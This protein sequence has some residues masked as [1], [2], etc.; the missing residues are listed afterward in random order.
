MGESQVVKKGKGPREV[1]TEDGK[2]RVV[3]DGWVLLP[4][5]DAAL[6]R[7]V[8]KAGPHYQVQE[9]RGRK[10]FSHGVWAPK[11]TIDREVARRAVEKED[12]AYQ[13]KLEVG[14]QR[15]A[16]QEALYGRVFEEAVFK[17]L[18]FHRRFGLLARRLSVAIAAHATPVGSGTV[19]RTK[20]ISVEERADAAI[21]AWMRHHT[22]DYDHMSIAR[23]KGERRRVRRELAKQSVALLERYRKGEAVEMCLLTEGLKRAVKP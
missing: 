13:K 22:T 11:E 6:T 17:R 12:P 4:P 7:R 1:I 5:G 2:V 16:G 15:R 3:P 8:K 18:G 20:R 21:I 23:V 10:N 14:R 19:A 9:K